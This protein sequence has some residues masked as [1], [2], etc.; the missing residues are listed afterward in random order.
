M[1]TRVSSTLAEMAANRPPATAR[2][3]PAAAGALQST[4]RPVSNATAK[5]RVTIVI[6]VETASPAV[7]RGAFRRCLFRTDEGRAPLRERS[8]QNTASLRIGVPVLSQVALLGA[9]AVMW[10]FSEPQAAPNARRL[11]LGA[12]C[13]DDD[14]PDP[15]GDWRPGAVKWGHGATAAL[16]SS[17][18]NVGARLR[19][20]P[21]PP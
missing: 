4:P 21:Q 6:A 11:C 20:V 9:A 12:G 1:A 10:M 5:L 7:V 2:S 18:W 8:T 13:S 14:C 16:L 3:S 17:P 19:Q 15:S